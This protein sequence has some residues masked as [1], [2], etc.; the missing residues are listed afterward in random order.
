[1]H[2]RKL[3]IMMFRKEREKGIREGEK[4]AYFIPGNGTASFVVSGG[5]R[6][7]NVAVVKIKGNPFSGHV[8][9]HLEGDAIE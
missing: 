8:N 6:D 4:L 9:R 5:N 1:M 2:V 7:A 3:R